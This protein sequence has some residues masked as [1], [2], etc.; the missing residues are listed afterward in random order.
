MLFRGIIS[1]WNLIN[2]LILLTFCGKLLILFILNSFSEESRNFMKRSLLE[3][4]HSHLNKLCLSLP[5]V[6]LFPDHSSSWDAHN[7]RCAWGR[8]LLKVCHFRRIQAPLKFV[9]TCFQQLWTH[10]IFDL[11]LSLPSLGVSSLSKVVWSLCYH[12]F[13]DLQKLL[14]TSRGLQIFNPDGLHSHCLFVSL[15]WAYTLWKC[16]SKILLTY[17]YAKWLNCVDVLLPHH[18][19]VSSHRIKHSNYNVNNC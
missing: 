8:Q 4:K 17:M 16:L 3:R 14:S 10:V 12:V 6:C 7:S 18:S 9:H 13:S 1:L 11:L 15:T 19:Q 5:V 2:I